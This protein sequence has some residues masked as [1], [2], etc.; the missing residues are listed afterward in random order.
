MISYLIAKYVD[1]LSRNEPVNVGVVVYDGTRALARFDGED[2]AARLD[3]RR[4]RHRI[5]GSQTYRAWAKYWRRVLDE[6]AL[7]SPELAALSSGDPAV[8]ESLLRIPPG[9]FYL[10]RGGT[11]LLDADS[12]DLGDTLNDLFRQLVREPDPPVPMTLREKSRQA[13]ATAGAPL[14]DEA[15]FKEQ[16]PV[17]LRV[18]GV[19]VEEEVSYAVMNGG[20]HYLQEMPFDPGKPRRSRKEASHCV[21]L[22]EHAPWNAGEAVILYDASDLTGGDYRLLQLLMK[23]APTVNVGDTD[24]AAGKIQEHLKLA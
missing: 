3:L 16:L 24:Y 10:E 11:I 15:R 6:P 12:R 1:D 21:F 7:L 23:F 2:D 17:R 13:L 19:E 22:L 4:V 18:E 5:T 20:W 14:D 9:D 8:I